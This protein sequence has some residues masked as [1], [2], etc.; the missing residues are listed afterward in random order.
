MP[1]LNSKGNQAGQEHG[2]QSKDKKAH[3][4]VVTDEIEIP[5]RRVH[6]D[7]LSYSDLLSL[8]AELRERIDNFR[9]KEARRLRDEIEALARTAGFSVRELF[10][11]NTALALTSQYNRGRK[12]VNPIKYVNPDNRSQTWSGFGKAPRWLKEKIEAGAN[13]EDFRIAPL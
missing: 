4:T 8:Q 12:S 7:K 2:S 10:P 11:G 1:N 13:K 5:M 3:L 9:D 6:L